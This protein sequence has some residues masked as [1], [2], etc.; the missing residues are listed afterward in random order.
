MVYNSI[1]YRVVYR[2]RMFGRYLVG[3]SWYLPNWYWRKTWSV[4]FGIIILAGTPFFLERGV[5]AP[6]FRGPAP[7]LRKKGF[8]AKPWRVPAKFFCA[9][10]TDRNTNQQVPVH[11]ISMPIPAKM[12]VSKRYTTLFFIELYT[13]SVFSDSIWWVFLC[14][15][16]TDTG[17]KLGQYILVYYF[18]RNPFFPWR[19]SHGP[20]F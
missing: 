12:P 3:V 16:R 18:G 11:G 5:M 20:L 2:F 7:I 14:I 19:G 8:P 6:F 17:G 4:H 15:Y 10:N 13:N 9:Q 1:L